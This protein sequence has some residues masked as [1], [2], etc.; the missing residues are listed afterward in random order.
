LLEDPPISLKQF[1]EPPA[2]EL[3]L[4]WDDLKPIAEYSIGPF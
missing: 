4:F 2:I 1:S 3:A